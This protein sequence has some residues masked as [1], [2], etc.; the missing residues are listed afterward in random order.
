MTS[1]TPPK[2]RGR[3]RKR[4]PAIT[5]P[6]EPRMMK[7]PRT[8]KGRLDLRID[9]QQVSLAEWDVDIR[10]WVLRCPECGLW[11]VQRVKLV[12]LPPAVARY[13]RRPGLGL[14]NNGGVAVFTAW[15]WWCGC[16]HT[17]AGSVAPDATEDDV[18]DKFWREVQV[19]ERT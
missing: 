3:P 2:K 16:G 1:D 18:Y 10:P 14:D 8:N 11:M 5:T 4:K 6:R 19:H 15:Y 13:C 7:A 12:A 9:S 17:E